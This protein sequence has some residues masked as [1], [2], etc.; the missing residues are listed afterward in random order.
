MNQANPQALGPIIDG[1]G[2]DPSLN[3]GDLVAAAAVVLKIIEP[4]GSVRL[5]IAW[6][7][8]LGW[9]ER[10]GML[11]AAEHMDLPLTT[12]VED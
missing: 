4:D 1:L 6:S 12:D 11:R 9:I 5:S 3:E 2:C 10:L 8:G 7:D